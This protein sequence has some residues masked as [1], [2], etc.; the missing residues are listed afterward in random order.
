VSNELYD[1]AR[2]DAG[3]TGH[4]PTS[5]WKW[6]L[7]AAEKLGCESQEAYDALVKAQEER[8]PPQKE[9]T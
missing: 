3:W 7:S 2:A 8:H 9:Q 4:D 1:L 6:A 5:R